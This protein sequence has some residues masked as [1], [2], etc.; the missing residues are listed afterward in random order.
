M[1]LKIAVDA[2]ALCADERRRFG[3][4]IFTENLIR[5]FGEYDAQHFYNL[6]GFSPTPP[7][8]KLSGN[9]HYHNLQPTPGWMKLRVSLQE[10]V[11]PSDIFLALNQAYP[12]TKAR[13]FGWS[14]GLSFLKYPHLYPDSAGKMKAQMERLTKR[15]EVTFV[16]STKMKDELLNVFPH[17]NAEV[18]PIGIPFDMIETKKQKRNKTFLFVGMNHPIKNVQTLTEI[19]NKFRDKKGR[20]EYKLLLVGPHDQYADEKNNITVLNNVSRVKLRTLYQTCAAYL[21]TSLYESFNIPVLEALSQNASV[22]AFESAI[23]PEM[24]SF[25]STVKTT[26]EMISAMKMNNDG[27]SSSVDQKKLHALFGW[28]HIIKLLVSYYD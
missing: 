22:I 16:T 11:H 7:D 8:L 26:D 2:G 27:N 25:V 5:A 13:V 23:I 3:T 12:A 28:N 17:A 6:Y 14:H 4:A 1:H 19:F 24:K 15:A 20:E 21:S 10:M 18:L 9:Q